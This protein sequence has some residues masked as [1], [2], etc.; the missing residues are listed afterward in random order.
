MYQQSKSFSATAL[1]V[2]FVMF[3]GCFTTKVASG[4]RPELGSQ[5]EHEDRQLFT[6]GGLV[7][8]SSAAGKECQKG[9]AT[10]ES[11]L[12]GVDI[13]VNIGLGVAGFLAGAYAC[14]S[15]STSSASCATLGAS[16]VPWLL[17]TRTVKYRC[18]DERGGTGYFPAQPVMPPPVPQAP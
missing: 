15:D 11:S 1:V 5:A 13:L 12:G 9:I 8:L 17:G 18:L 2:L 6:L 7:P 3:S 4:G 10:T 16:L 14:N